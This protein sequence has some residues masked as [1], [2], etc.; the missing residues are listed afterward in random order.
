MLNVAALY[1]RV[2][3]KKQKEGETIQSQLD[4]L[5][6]YATEKGYTIPD[7]MEF[8]DE[9]YSG[10]LL[11]RPA[12]DELRE[13]VR[14]G[15]INKVL[16]FSPDRLSRKYAYQLFLKDEFNKCGVELSFLNSPP[17][18]T[19]EAQLTEHFQGIFAEYERTQIAE[20][21]RRGRLYKAR[22]G[23]VSAL[24][25]VPYGYK[26]IKV[27]NLISLEIDPE[28][29]IVVKEI[30]RLYLQEEM[31]LSGVSRILDLRGVK[32]CKGGKSWDHVTIKGILENPA[33]TGSAYFGKTERS[34]GIPGR[35]VRYK[36]GVVVQPRYARKK[37]PEDM[38]I[39][40]PIPA[41]ISENDFQAVQEKLKKNKAFFAR[42]TKEPSL[43]QGLLVCG[44]CGKPYYK[45]V[46]KTKT[47]R[48]GY[49][50]CRNTMEKGSLTPCQNRSL[51]LEELDNL[52]FDEVVELLKNPSLIEAELKRQIEERSEKQ[53][54]TKEI[55]V[56][57]E[58]EQISKARNKLLDIYQDS[59]SLSLQELRD[60]IEKLNRRKSVL[61]TDLKRFN[62]LKIQLEI[63][64]DPVKM[65]EEY[66]K[67]LGKASEELPFLEKRKLVRL[68]VEE[69]IIK[70]KE[71]KIKH[72]VPIPG[73]S[74]QNSPLVEVDRLKPTATLRS[75]G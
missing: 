17:A 11:K 15:S 55:E 19:P 12:L 37:L 69:V 27:N 47:K 20:R 71:I 18:N 10:A 66:T 36:S 64:Q 42:N 4:S 13:L 63:N 40:I 22:Q 25:S 75:C 3:S 54:S 16:V 49:Y 65:L 61:E 21:C 53:E 9:G 59:E 74:G 58:L 31:T 33:Y 29:S 72:C 39:E 28:T 48:I 56:R 43:L 73:K 24:P 60:R 1:A 52:I 70:P 2:S 30:Y 45:K 44:D 50:C 34:E 68:L 35:I 5:R 41:F 62:A 57:K 6:R 7:G 23:H 14:E 38:W 67:R 46:R 26:R 8:K 51:R 32:T